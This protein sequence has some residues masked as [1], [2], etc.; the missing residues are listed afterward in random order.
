MIT[1]NIYFLYAKYYFRLTAPQNAAR[2]TLIRPLNPGRRG[3]QRWR[4]RVGLAKVTSTN[5]TLKRRGWSCP[6]L[7]LG[8]DIQGAGPLHVSA[9]TQDM[10]LG[11]LFPILWH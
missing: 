6:G 2:Q 7:T 3:T 4:G 1:D 9:S 10:R 5:V 11:K 8:E